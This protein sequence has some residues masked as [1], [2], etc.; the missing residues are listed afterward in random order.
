MN[1]DFSTAK[2]LA[3]MFELVP[4][5]NSMKDNTIPVSSISGETF[6]LLQNQFRLYIED[7]LGLKDISE[8]NND[9]LQGVLQLLIDIRKEAKGK[10]DFTTSD[11]IRK[12]LAQMGI[13]IKDEKDGGMSYSFE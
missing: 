7:I 8:A 3:N 10:K 6:C 12:Q 4:I 2:V 11:N 13:L 9:R 5:I 1:D